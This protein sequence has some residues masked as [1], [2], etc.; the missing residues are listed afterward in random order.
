M[1]TI[2]VLNLGS[3]SFKFKLFDMDL[4]CPQV[5]SGS[6][7]AIGSGKSILKVKAGLLSEETILDC[8]THG[9]AFQ[10]C[11]ERLYSSNVLKD[12]SSLDAVG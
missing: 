10:M 3:T 1:K 8:P 5:G 6:V 11:M 9:D 7:D 2:M 12:L 4:K